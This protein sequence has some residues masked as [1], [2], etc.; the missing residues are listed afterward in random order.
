[1]QAATVSEYLTLGEAA[2]RLGTQLWK[3]QRLFDRGLMPEPR[4]IGRCRVL[5]EGD[6]PEL[7]A[8]LK[9]AGY[10]RAAS[11]ASRVPREPPR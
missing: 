7:E 2:G 8:A 3:V 1:M 4:R 10:I 11:H 9:Q 6:L 5:L